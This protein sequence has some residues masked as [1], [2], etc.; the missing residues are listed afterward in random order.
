MRIETCYFCSQPCYPSKGI[1]FVRNDSKVFRFCRSKCHKNFKMKRN[2]RKLAWTK[3]FRRAHG[4]EMTVDST[5]Q[6]A[7]RR[8]V[9]VR[10]NREL[11]ATTLQA[12]Q[13]VGEIRARREKQIKL[14][15]L[16]I[17]PTPESPSK[18]RPSFPSD[19]MSLAR[20]TI[21]FLLLSISKAFAAPPASPSSSTS[22][23]SSTLPPTSFPPTLQR[24]CAP[25]KL[26]VCCVVASNSSTTTTTT[27]TRSLPSPVR[28]QNDGD[29]TG[30]NGAEEGEG[31]GRNET[32]FDVT[33]VTVHS[34]RL[35]EAGVDCDDLATAACCR[36]I[37]VPIGAPEF[38]DSKTERLMATALAVGVGVAAAAFFGRAG[39]VALRRYRGGTNAMGKA[40][41]KGG[42]EKQMTR[43]EA[44]L[45]LETS[46]RG[47]TREMIR[48][49]H[50]QM[51]LLNHPDRGGSPYLA[52]KINEAKEFMEKGA[53]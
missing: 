26:S 38:K 17:S 50:R 6:F 10:Y 3:S 34:C 44:A 1:T 47:A 18:F 20:L 19:A 33:P 8:N 30:D 11:V 43:R 49:K 14:P 2:P 40:F 9:P 24:T 53:T 32:T 42:F 7:Q 15:N 5:L 37:H 45:I 48:K 46:E 21:G 51:M 16:R 12:M 13:R 22:P 52:T 31:A 36:V 23:F 39:L 25:D 28:G 4:K 27:S 29:D 35:K 41:Y